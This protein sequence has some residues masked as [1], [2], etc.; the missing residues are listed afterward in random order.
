MKLSEIE[1]GGRYTAKVSGVVV[2]VR[3]VEIKEIPPPAWTPSWD[4]RWRK[5]IHAVNEATGRKITLRSPQRLRAKAPPPKYGCEFCSKPENRP[6]G[7][8]ECPYCR[9]VWGE[10]SSAKPC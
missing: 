5:I 1:V 7:G 9:K 4:A 10:G 6:S 2:V 8:F 3:V